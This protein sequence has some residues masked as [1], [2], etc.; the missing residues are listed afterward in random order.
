MKKIFSI[1]GAL[2]AGAMMFSCSNLYDEA[3]T[4]GTEITTNVESLAQFAAEN[5][6]AQTVEVT[7]NGEWIAVAPAN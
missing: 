6:E 4:F 3:I 1:F 7:S 2:L 5:A